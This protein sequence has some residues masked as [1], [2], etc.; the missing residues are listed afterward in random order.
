MKI[1]C[2]I[3][4]FKARVNI[5]MWQI[6]KKYEVIS[7]CSQNSWEHRTSIENRRVGKEQNQGSLAENASF[8]YSVTYSVTA[9][10]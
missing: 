5:K 10:P 9:F 2:G 8:L 6:L 7:S 1:R 4:S 3:F